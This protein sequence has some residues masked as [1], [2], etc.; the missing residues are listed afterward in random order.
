MNRE[1]II[2]LS[3]QAGN[4]WDSLLREDQETLMRFGALVAAKERERC[5]KVAEDRK[6]ITPE[7]QLDQHYN[8]AC[9][10]CAA[11]IRARGMNDG[12]HK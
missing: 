12:L 11:A 5:A 3:V 6:H 2:N 8:Q 7:W 4:D 9:N 1:E 10:H